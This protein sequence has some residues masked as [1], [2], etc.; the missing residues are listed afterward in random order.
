MTRPARYQALEP[1]PVAPAPN[2]LVRWTFVLMIFSIPWEYPGRS[3]PIEIPTLTA[4]IFLLT[5][6]FQPRACYARRPAALFWFALYIYAFVV[7]AVWNARRAVATDLNHAD[8]WLEVSRLFLLELECVL[9]FWA[10]YNLLRSPRIART[11]LLTL[12]VA[13]AALAILPFLGIARTSHVQWGGGERVT[14]LGQN[15][16]NAAMILAAGIVALLGL[17]YGPERPPIRP[18]WLIWPVIMLIGLSIV[19]T[20]SRGGTLALCAGLAALMFSNVRTIWTAVRSALVAV[21]AIGLIVFATYKSDLMRRRFEESVE[22]G[23]LAGRER[24]Y[25]GLWQMFKQRPVLG[26]GPINNKYELGIR[27]DERHWPR[28]DAHNLVLEV[29]TATGLVGTVPFLA[30]I[31][32][33]VAG[34]WRGRRSTHGFLP[35]ALMGVVLIANMSGDWVISKLLWLVLAY[36]LASLGYPREAAPPRGPPLRSGGRLAGWEPSRVPRA[37]TQPLAP[38]L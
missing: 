12:A 25:P 2:R 24:I 18:K 20:A 21:L 33:C 35:I 14:A 22:N 6:F 28:R 10:L 16:N 27:L 31:G 11:G 13:C 15:A 36:G 1:M 4:A 30:G 3:F 9:V 23:S 38:K 17:E 34:A 32:L 19:E 8:Y 37:S 7:A 29:L 26:W 5:T